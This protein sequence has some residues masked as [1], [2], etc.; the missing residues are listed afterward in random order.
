MLVY[1]TK[2]KDMKRKEFLSTI[3][4]G[5]TA[6]C[7]ACL[8]AACS[9]EEMVTPTSGGS[10]TTPSQGSTPIT[11][12]LST[13]LRAVNDFISKSGVIVIRTSAGNN[14]SNFLA[15]SSAC[16]HAG[17]TVEYNNSK[18]TFFCSAHGSAF[19]S[20]GALVTGPATKGLSKLSVEITGTNL[21]VKT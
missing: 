10:S 13:E 7:V 3:T 1:I 4:G 20:D 8:A 11:V 9:K 21:V 6:T 15:V 19:A 16:P 2:P 17:S 18:S 5:I 12:N 14:P